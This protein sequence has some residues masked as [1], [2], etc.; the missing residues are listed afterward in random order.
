[1]PRLLLR[2]RI[3]PIVDWVCAYSN[4][5]SIY[6]GPNVKT[7]QTKEKQIKRENLYRNNKTVPTL[8]HIRTSGIMFCLSYVSVF[9]YIEWP[10]LLSAD[11][12]NIIDV[13]NIPRH[14]FRTLRTRTVFRNNTG[15]SNWWGCDSTNRTQVCTRCAWAVPYTHLTPPTQ[16]TG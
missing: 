5:I 7:K 15:G 11:A 3:L 2:K 13:P 16:A 1:M 14:T 6:H 12:G 9:F 8:T 10:S 4:D